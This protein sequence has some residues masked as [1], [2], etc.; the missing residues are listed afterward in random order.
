MSAINLGVVAVSIDAS[1]QLFQFYKSG[2]ISST[3][4]GT[5]ID[6]A[7]SAVGYGYD[8]KT[9]LNYYLIRNSWG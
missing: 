1:T 7:V 2:V 8:P 5:N 6:H 9:N 3:S 4:C